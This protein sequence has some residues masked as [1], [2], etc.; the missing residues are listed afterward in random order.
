[1]D[2]CLAVPFH[3]QNSAGA[4][5]TYAIFAESAHEEPSTV[6]EL[7]YCLHVPAKS[8]RRRSRKVVD[9]EVIGAQ[10]QMQPIL[11]VLVVA[12]ALR[13][14]LDAGAVCGAPGTA[15]CLRRALRHRQRQHASRSANPSAWRVS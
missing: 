2:A 5:R 13:E 15:G 6:G 10:V 12:G 7:V 1:M 14:H 9:H 8:R 11:V 4:R 3:G